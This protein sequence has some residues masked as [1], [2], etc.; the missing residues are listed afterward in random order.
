MMPRSRSSFDI[1]NAIA[2]ATSLS[3]AEAELGTSFDG[4]SL[5]SFGLPSDKRSEKRLGAEAVVPTPVESSPGFDDAHPPSEGGRRPPKLPDLANV[6]SPVARC[7]RIIDWITEA[8]EATD[9]FIADAAGLPIAGEFPEA[10][11]RLASASVVVSAIRELAAGMPGSA[12][13]IFELHVGEGPF[14]QLIGFEAAKMLFFVGFTRATPLT[15]RQAH[16]VRLACR[17]ALSAVESAGRGTRE[18]SVGG[19]GL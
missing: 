8:V 7:Q 13:S 11:A 9:V 15:Y 1:S 17:H 4:V 2:T 16:A 10:E 6:V 3:S 19:G 14:F 5:V 12:S 18:A